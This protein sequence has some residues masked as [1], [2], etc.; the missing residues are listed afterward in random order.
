MAFL[1]QGSL[2]CLVT[3]CSFKTLIKPKIVCQQ[4]KPFLTTSTAKSSLST[5]SKIKDIVTQVSEQLS[6]MNIPE[7]KLS[8]NYLVSCCVSNSDR[9]VPVL[10]R[11]WEQHRDTCLDQMQLLKLETLV[12]C[13]L[14]HMPLQ[15]L[16]GNW[17]FRDLTLLCRPPVFIPR[18]ESEQ[19]VDL[20][21]EYLPSGTGLRLLEIGPGTGALSLSLLQECENIVDITCVDRSKAAIELTI[22]N[23]ELLGFSNKLKTVLGRIGTDIELDLDEKYDLIF[24]NPP[25]ILR[26]DLPK[27]EPQIS[28][29][30]D[31]RALDGGSEGLD[32]ILP[33]LEMAGVKLQA[34]GFVILEVDPCHPFILPE[35]L[36]KLQ[37][38]F[39]VEKVVKDFAEK[40]RFMILKKM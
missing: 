1:S 37:H 26:K 32:V 34:G 3:R 5:T 33:I 40:D 38:Q 39:S 17:D 4:V 20:I 19:M 30:E 6:A 25:Y 16:V 24:S 31:L 21:K 15:Y 9:H 23:A 2:K 36:E 27:L 8:A 10:A 18:P 7:P 22:A 28:L 12:Q 29:Y 11:D 35:K 13:R 14:A